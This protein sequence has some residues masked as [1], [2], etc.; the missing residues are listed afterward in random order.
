MDSGSDAGPPV[1]ASPMSLIKAHSK[2]RPALEEAVMCKG[3]DC[4]ECGPLDS[5]RCVCSV[6][7]PALRGTE[8]VSV[9][10]EEAREEE[11]QVAMASV[12]S[13]STGG[14]DP[15]PSELVQS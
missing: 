11:V 10:Q 4:C 6:V 3:C 15:D 12:P 5:F 14:L 8:D 9:D 7:R 13:E 1:A 2:L